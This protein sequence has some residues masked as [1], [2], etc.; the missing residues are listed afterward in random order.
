M[1]IAMG[2]TKAAPA[3]PTSPMYEV[4]D[5]TKLTSQSGGRNGPTHNKIHYK[6]ITN[7]LSTYL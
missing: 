3:P 4:S 7:P 1:M 6:R 2:G 5:F